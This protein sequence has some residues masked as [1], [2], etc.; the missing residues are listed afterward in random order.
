MRARSNAEA[1][2]ASRRCGAATPLTTVSGSA[3]AS[4]RAAAARAAAGDVATWTS[5][6][7]CA[8]VGCGG[9]EERWEAWRKATAAE[10]GPPETRMAVGGGD[11]GRYEARPRD[12]L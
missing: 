2:P 6:S 10:A 5:R 4:A 3:R 7:G 12:T 9:R 11:R 1:S 8:G